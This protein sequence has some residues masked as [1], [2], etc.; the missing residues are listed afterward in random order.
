MKKQKTPRSDFPL[1]NLGMAYIKRRLPLLGRSYVS[2]SR[3]IV[4]EI[5]IDGA[6]CE[7]CNL[8]CLKRRRVVVSGY[9][10]DGL[11]WLTPKPRKA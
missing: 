6:G 10:T 2:G 8:Y 11:R 5:W 3:F 1:N 7:L 9:A 4:T